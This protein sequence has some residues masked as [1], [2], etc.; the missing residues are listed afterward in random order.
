MMWSWNLSIDSRIGV[1]LRAKGLESWYL[2][3]RGGVIKI[4]ERRR[5]GREEARE[6][7]CLCGK[8]KIAG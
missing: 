1:M 7:R 2:I 4:R 5:E 3:L 8:L 6:M